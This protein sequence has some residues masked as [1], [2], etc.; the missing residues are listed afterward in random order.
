MQY[1]ISHGGQVGTRFRTISEAGLQEL[2]EMETTETPEGLVM[3]RTPNFDMNH[4]YEL[5]ARDESDN[6]IGSRYEFK[7][8][9]NPDGSMDF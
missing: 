9:S 4:V 6:L 2:M 1:V 8:L 3:S 7:G 5:V